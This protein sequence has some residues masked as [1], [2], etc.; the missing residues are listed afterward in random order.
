MNKIIHSLQQNQNRTVLADVFISEC[1]C[2]L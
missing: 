2:Y 1:S